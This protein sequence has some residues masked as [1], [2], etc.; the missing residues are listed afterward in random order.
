MISIESEERPWGHFFV[1]HDER[2]FKFKRIEVDSG[3]RGR[4]FPNI[5]TIRAL[6]LGR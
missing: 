3:V 1:M 4:D 5:T 6:R 2:T